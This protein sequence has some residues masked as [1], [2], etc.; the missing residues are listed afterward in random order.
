[1]YSLSVLICV[2]SNTDINDS[3]LIDAIDSLNN[4]TY[5]NFETVLVLDQCWN[6][7]RKKLEDR[8]MV[9][10]FTLIERDKKEGLALAKNHGLSVVKT[11]WVAYLDADDLYE[12]QKIEKQLQYIKS[13]AVDF[14]GTH[15][16][17][18]TGKDR[19]TKW[20]SVFSEH[21]YNK[22]EDIV[23]VLPRKN[24]LTHGS[25]M[26]RMSSLKDLGYYNN[27]KAME[28]YDLW[29]RASKSYKFFQLPERLY[30]LSLGT[31]VAR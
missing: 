14:L 4:Q 15:A 28:D 6:K 31:S 24:V 3:F 22:H 21:R 26:I 18:I 5:R 16:W 8:G 30:L 27:V 7:T 19:K 13:N 23:R 25:M 2:H 17:N 11:D 29:K 12:P 9:K 10:D 20:P 1:M